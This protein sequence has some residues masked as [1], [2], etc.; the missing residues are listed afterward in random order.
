MSLFEP[1]MEKLKKGFYAKPGGYD[2]FCKDLENVVEKY[3]SQTNKEVKVLPTFY[4]TTHLYTLSIHYTH[5]KKYAHF[6][7]TVIICIHLFSYYYLGKL[8]NLAHT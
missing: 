2:L 7:H 6:Y 1:M 8:W 4:F 5:Y 3:K